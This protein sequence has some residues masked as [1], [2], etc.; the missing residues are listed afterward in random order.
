[1]PAAAH[2]LSVS[3][4]HVVVGEA[5]LTIRF[6][7]PLDD[8]DLLLRVDRDLDGTISDAE[9][10]GAGP[11]VR[12]Y[13]AAHS[14]VRA[15]AGVLSPTLTRTARWA[16]ESGFPYV[17]LMTDY[18]GDH[19]PRQ[20]ALTL[21]LL[22]DLYPDHRTLID[23]EWGARREAFVAQHGNTLT[24][25]DAGGG[26]LDHLRTFLALGV[27]HILT[28]YDHLLFLL[29]LLVASRRVRDVVT[30]VTA[31]TVAHSV[32]LAAA[33]LGLVSPPARIV[34]AVI[35]LSIAYVGIENLLMQ[36]PRARWQLA[37]GFG[38]IHGFGFAS[39]LRDMALPRESLA[40]SLVTFNLGVE[41]GQLAVVLLTWPLLVRLQRS[42]RDAAVRKAVSAAVAVL[43]LYWFVERIM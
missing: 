28:G 1:M 26:L 3:Y 19:R 16:D 5:G 40:A 22:I 20:V 2:P 27:E 18:R 7:L 24:V 37:F 23:V 8:M 6:R 17:E 11:A 10:A 32:T 15:G 13:I 36:A 35:A 14:E 4:A 12:D 38:L 31:F 25:G 33:T 41:L 34:E 39:I 43:G 9:L 21:R 30:I 42:T 29:G